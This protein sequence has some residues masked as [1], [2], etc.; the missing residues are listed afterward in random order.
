MRNRIKITV[1]T[2]CYNAEAKISETVRSV[3]T[4]TY[5]DIE[6]IVK[7][8]CSGDKTLEILRKLQKEENILIFSE[9]D[10][11]IYDAMNTAVEY[12][13]GDYVIFLNA[14][15]AFADEYVLEEL[16]QKCTE[17]NCPDILFGNII[18]KETNGS[19]L[20][21][22]YSKI[23]AKKYYYLSGDTICHQVV[24]ARRDSLLKYPFD[25]TYSICADRNWLLTLIENKALF[26]YIDRVISIC[27]VEGYS[28]QNQ[29]RYEWETRR[30]I[31]EHFSWEYYLYLVVDLAK[32]NQFARK[33]MRFLGKMMFHSRKIEG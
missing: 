2:V 26:E 16:S 11:G 20:S 33:G 1:V 24:M 22:N 27:E 18:Y 25:I 30:C 15:D 10:N 13:S 31:R 14:G 12:A 4:Q 21:R 3:I 7:D 29:Q 28:T 8:G 6:Y 5:P 32:K 19:R 23:C 17:K 9:E